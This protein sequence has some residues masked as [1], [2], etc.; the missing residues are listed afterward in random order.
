MKAVVDDVVIAEADSG[1]VIEI[2]GNQYFPPS[3]IDRSLFEESPTE[4]RCG[5]KGDCQY[6]SI[7]VDGRWLS[8]LAWTY[9]AAPPGAV[10]TVGRD[11]SGY[12]AFDKSVRLEP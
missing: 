2:E 5:W 1:D 3:A 10:A 8:D 9:P 4:Y 11:F 7:R 12:V 6:Y